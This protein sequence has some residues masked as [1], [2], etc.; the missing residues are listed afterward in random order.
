MAFGRTN[1]RR[2]GQSLL[3][4]AMSLCVLASQDAFAQAGRV[5]VEGIPAALA[6]DLKRLQREEPNPETLFD[7]QRQADR[8]AGVVRQFLE[9]QGYYLAEVE[10]RAE[11]VE[12]FTRNV[13]VTLGPL[14]TYTTRRIEYLGSDPDEATKVELDSLLAPIADGVPARAQPVIETGDALVAR[15]RA[16]GYPDA[17]AEPVDAL[18]DGR[19]HTVELAFRL[20]PGFRASFG[21]VAISGLGR[22]KEDYI[23]DLKPWRPN[24]RFTP[25]KLDEFRA[26]LAE[27]G[28]FATAATRLAPEGAAQDNGLMQRDV[29]VEVVER[30]RRTVALGAS[31]STSDGF[32]VEGEWELRNISGRGDSINVA[33]QVATLERRL[34][35]SWRRPNI[36]RYGRNIR[37]GAKIE[38][39]ET[40]AFDQAGASVT[41]TVE[42]QLT[43][44]VRGSIG[45]EFGYASTLED[46]ARALGEDRNNVYILS[47]IGT[48]EY[49][50]VRDVLDPQAGIRARVTAEPGLTYGDTNIGYTRLTGEASAYFDLSENLIGAVRGKLGTIAGP[51]GVPADRKFFAGGGGSVRGYEYQS[52][53]PKT[54]VD[55]E[56][57]LEGGRSLVEMSAELRWRASDRLGY[58]AFFDAGAAGSNVEPPVAEMRS[59]VG[60]G[61]RY[62]AGFGPLRA[63]IAIPLNKED[64][65]A[66][67]QIYIS[68]GQAF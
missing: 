32:G 58:V 26:R 54:L 13:T 65:D 1:L 23:Q 42:E 52:L 6:D 59:G 29:L 36:K 44:R 35:T 2:A 20:Q 22:T 10:P 50:G 28:L 25:E 43:P 37:L 46:K 45:G 48:L 60:L 7:A 15:L 33:A 27:T 53:S 21:D 19:Q 14:F 61:L 34:E 5:P 67:F 40:D 17:R 49:V 31:A 18:A 30:K 12:T 8:A 38:D 24:E 3:A 41:A 51:N 57:T 9:S 66:D 16:A 47:S 63:D 4:L 62:Y 64:G 39:F 11:G 68:I 55:G 56:I